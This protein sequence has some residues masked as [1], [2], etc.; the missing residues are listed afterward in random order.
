MPASARLDELPAFRA[1]MVERQIRGRGVAD[2]CVLAAMREVPREAFVPEA[3]A[4]F[5]YQDSPLPIEAGQTISQPY[6]VAR[7]IELAKLGPYDRVLEVGA[8]SGYAAAVM[9]RIAAQVFAV[10]RHA[11][12]A[13]AARRRLAELGYDNITVYHRDGTEGLPEH[14]PFDAIVVSAG[15]DR[16][17]KALCSELAVGGRLIIPVGSRRGQVLERIIRRGDE[18]FEEE[19]HG[20]VAFVPLIAGEDGTEGRVAADE[21]E[22]DGAPVI[23]HANCAPSLPVRG[24]KTQLAAADREGAH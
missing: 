5:A 7:M 21:G 16:V 20:M 24:R 4:A 9:S 22:L 10:E 14:A 11:V 15:G 8:G 3:L 19:G 17:P 1:A 2:A 23:W 13:R 6:I 18:E 12:L